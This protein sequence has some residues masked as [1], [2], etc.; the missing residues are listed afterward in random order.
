M[1][2]ASV[3]PTNYLICDGTSYLRTTYSALFAVIG[4]NFGAPNIN[5]FRVP[6]FRGIFPRGW[7]NTNTNVF[8][9]PDRLTRT[10]LYPGGATG[11]NIGSYQ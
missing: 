6:D 11:N 7:N 2:G 8:A 3:A 5:E 1:F 10:A 9:D 4:T